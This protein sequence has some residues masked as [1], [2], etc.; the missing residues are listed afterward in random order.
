LN[1]EGQGLSDGL[2]KQPP[3]LMLDDIVAA[4]NL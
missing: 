4:R 1:A 2:G 3:L